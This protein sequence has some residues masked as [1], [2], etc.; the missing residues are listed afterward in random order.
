ME[1]GIFEIGG[2]ARKIR[3]FGGASFVS[4]EAALGAMPQLAFSEM[5]DENDAADAFTKGGM[6]YSVER[7]A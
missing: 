6:V 4:R 7:V 3:V 1:Y 5:D 2:N